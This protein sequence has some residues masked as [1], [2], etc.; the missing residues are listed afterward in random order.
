MVV[1]EEPSEVAEGAHEGAVGATP[2]AGS[3]RSV[4]RV[5]AEIDGSMIP[6]KQGQLDEVLAALAQQYFSCQ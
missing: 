1:K 2:C 4:E 6:I 3:M 5:I